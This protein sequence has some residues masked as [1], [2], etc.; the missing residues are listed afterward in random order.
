MISVI[1]CT[2]NPNI[3]Y[4]NQ[5]LSSLI[6][7]TVDKKNWELILVDNNSS[8][9]FLEEI[10]ISWHPHGKVIFEE[11]QGLTPARIKGIINSVGEYLVFVDDDNLLE[12]NYLQEVLNIAKKWPTIGTFGG[13]IDGLFEQEPE[14]WTKEFWYYLA[15]REVNKD[16]WSNDVGASRAEPCGAGLC[17]KKEV[18]TRY[19][20]ELQN[21][22]LRQ[23]LGRTCSLLTS[24]EDTDIVLTA[25]EMG[26]GMG[27]FKSLRMKHIIPPQRLTEEYLIK[28]M[29]GLKFS[30]I[31]L[32]KLRHQTLKYQYSIID[33]FRNFYYLF[34][35][36]GQA[37]RFYK[38][39]IKGEMKA[40]KFIKQNNL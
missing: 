2:Y 28:L 3:H 25:L 9:N 14:S 40:F 24:G 37:R 31:V 34:R 8:N 6:E 22:P 39:K 26:F 15:L 4:L 23:K 29:E 30:H 35:L 19:I 10:D 7:Q 38:A 32:S 27:V 11:K 33:R 5:V 21:Q 1:I 13:N 17:I 36:N 18:A 12:S 16:F 20:D